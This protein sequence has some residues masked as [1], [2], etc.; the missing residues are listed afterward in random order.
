MPV[1]RIDDEVWAWLKQH[2]RPLED[3]PNTVLRRIA[4]L[5]R[6][7]AE[8]N[9]RELSESGQPAAMGGVRRRDMKGRSRII[10]GY[11]RDLN[12]RWGVGALHALYREDGK[13]Y[14]HLTHFPGA[15]FDARGYVLFKTQEQYRNSPHLQHGVQLHVKGGI[16]SLPGYVLKA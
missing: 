8:P 13:F 11:G 9:A 7:Q 1:I 12:R 5:D 10:T 15:L 16:S 3:T 6:D 14:N 2:A 4:G